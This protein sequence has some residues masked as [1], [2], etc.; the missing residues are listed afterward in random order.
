MEDKE[1]RLKGILEDAKKHGKRSYASYSYYKDK[2]WD[3]NLSS[4]EYEQACIELA[5]ILKI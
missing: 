4:K 1:E 3:L 5:R 2:F